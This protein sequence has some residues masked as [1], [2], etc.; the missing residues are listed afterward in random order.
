MPPFSKI[1][2]CFYLMLTLNFKL[3]YLLFGQIQNIEKFHSNML[4]RAMTE[5]CFT[6]H[7]NDLS[8]SC[9]QKLVQITNKIHRLAACRWEVGLGSTW[10]VLTHSFWWKSGNSSV[11]KQWK[12]LVSTYC[13]VMSTMSDIYNLKFWLLHQLLLSWTTTSTEWGLLEPLSIKIMFSA[14]LLH[15]KALLYLI[16]HRHLRALKCETSTT[17]QSQ[18]VLIT[19]V[20]KA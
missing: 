2:M 4:I 10:P 3:I 11:P 13:L 8:F 18:L 15:I 14:Q 16:G 19:G 12:P 17:S 6:D 9:Q 20:K 5:S 1:C 7:S